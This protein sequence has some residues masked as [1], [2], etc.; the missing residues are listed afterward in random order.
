MGAVVALDDLLSARRVWRGQPVGLPAS[1]PEPT[2]HA[3]LDEVLPAGGWPEHA[4]SEI[5]LSADGVGELALV[6]PTLARLTR[7]GQR[8]ALV[9]PPYRLHAPAWH[10]AGLDL[11]QLQVIEATPRDAFWAAE[12]CMRSATCKAVLFWP[13]KPNDRALRR[14]A[15]AAAEGQCLG[16]AFRPLC[17]AANPSPAALRLAIESSDRAVRV[18]KSRGGTPPARPIPLAVAH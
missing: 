1:A 3:A 14:L 11:R 13:K 9:A 16:I 5:L 2:G 15:T 17:E 6:W 8:V 7:A 4:L 12:Q 10:S 18:L